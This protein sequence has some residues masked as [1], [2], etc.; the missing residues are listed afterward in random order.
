M[1]P[2]TSTTPEAPPPPP[3]V[4]SILEEM[5]RTAAGKPAAPQKQ[6]TAWRTSLW[7]KVGIC[8]GLALMFLPLA[9]FF[10]PD[11]P[12]GSE[13]EGYLEVDEDIAVVGWAWD[14][15]HPNDSIKVEIDDGVHPK[16]VVAADRPRGDLKELGKGNGKHGFRFPVPDRVRDG[17]TYNVT[18][19]FYD[20]KRPLENS[21]RK[22][23]YAK[24]TEAAKVQ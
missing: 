7:W 9:L 11:A 12:L 24:D 19:R 15:A 23:T 6:P 3:S 18:V 10:L 22:I 17:K 1:D 16:M 21:P 20:T 14:K 4:K 2:K 13:F 8:V 5:N